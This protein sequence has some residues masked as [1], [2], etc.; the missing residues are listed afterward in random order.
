LKDEEKT[1]E[2]AYHVLRRFD[3][4][5]KLLGSTTLNVRGN[6]SDETSYL[7]SSPDRVGWFTRG[8][9]YI[10]F[11]LDGSEMAR[12]GGPA[13]ANE[14][15]ISGGALSPENEVVAGRLGKGK[16]E[17]DILDREHGTWIPV[18]LP[19]EFAP[20]WTRVLGF[21]GTT[22]VIKITSTGLR[23]FNTK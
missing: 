2:I 22:L 15:H 10:E 14:R 19:P 3:P 4:S 21:D 5:G 12:Y 13:G 20:T 9:E 23:R 7:R 18:S 11:S 1:R 17:L 8:G 16:A 6:T